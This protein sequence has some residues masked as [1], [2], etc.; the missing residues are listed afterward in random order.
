M[1]TILTRN[2]KMAVMLE[3]VSG[4]YETPAN[5]DFMPILDGSENTPDYDILESKEISAGLDAKPGRPTLQNGQVKVIVHLKGGASGAAP[6]YDPLLQSV[7]TAPTTRASKTTVGNAALCAIL[8]SPAPT[9]TTFDISVAAAWLEAGDVILVDVSATATPSWEQAEVLTA[10]FDVDHESIVLTEALTV[11]PT[12]THEIQLI[13]RIDVGS[14]PGYA[15]QDIILVDVSGDGS[16]Y[17]ECLILEVTGTTT[18]T[19]KVWPYLSAEPLTGA[20]VLGGKT[21]KCVSSGQSTVT[22]TEFDDCDAQDGVRLD[23]AGCRMNMTIEGAE[24]GAE[25]QLNFSGQ[26]SQWKIADSGTSLVTLGLVPDTGSDHY[27]PLCLGMTICTGDRRTGVDMHN[28][29]LD[30]GY[31]IAKR[32]SMVPSSGSRGTF[33]SQR[34]VA[35][36]FTLDMEDASQYENWIARE[37][38]ALFLRWEDTNQVIVLIIPYMQ[39]EKIAKGDADGIRT[40][41][42]NWVANVKDSIGPMA[43]AFFAPLS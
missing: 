23:F 10:T 35:G 3:A 15:A 17:D 34:K 21:Y 24:V 39:K 26:A 38:V 18:Q 22:V 33:Y 25:A 42:V 1:E 4:E 16:A 29:S 13:S 12:A 2:T 20:T 27:A 19:V 43:I 5:T 32:K 7:L 11:A 6:H 41:T 40:N 36:S 28:F 9:D 8:A 14:T 30:M 31:A 37:E